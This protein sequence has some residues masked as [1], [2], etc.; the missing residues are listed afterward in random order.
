[1]RLGSWQI[2]HNGGGAAFTVAEAPHLGLAEAMGPDSWPWPGAK[3]DTDPAL[4][5]YVENVDTGL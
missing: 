1:L 2:Y 3:A 5:C 4:P